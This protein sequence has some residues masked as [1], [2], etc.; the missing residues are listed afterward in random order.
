MKNI[1]S[2]MLQ[3]WFDSII[4]TI[5]EYNI[6]SENMYNMNENWFSIEIIEA[7]INRF[8]NLIKLSQVDK[9]ELHRS[10]VSYYKRLTRSLFTESYYIDCFNFSLISTDSI[11]LC[12]SIWII[13]ED[14]DWWDYISHDEASA[15]NIKDRMID[16]LYQSIWKCIQLKKYWKRIFWCRFDFFSICQDLFD[17]LLHLLPSF[18]HHLLVLQYQLQYFHHSTKKC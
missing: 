18:H 6:H 12:W 10:N 11:S 1:T 17:I 14:D 3:Q 2:K 5:E 16:S 4:D 13:E 15:S 7:T 9:N 8:E